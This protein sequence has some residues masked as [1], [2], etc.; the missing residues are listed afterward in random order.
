ML[1]K[2]LRFVIG[3]LLLFAVEFAV[4]GCSDEVEEQVDVIKEKKERQ[5]HHAEIQQSTEQEEALLVDATG[6]PY[7]KMSASQIAQVKRYDCRL[8]KQL[9]AHDYKKNVK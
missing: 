5:E 7:D 8:R 3:G 2:I 1:V 4:V 6:T 9:I